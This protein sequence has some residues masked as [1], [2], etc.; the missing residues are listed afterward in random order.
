M[1]QHQEWLKY[2][3]MDT[4]EA[5]QLYMEKVKELAEIYQAKEKTDA[6]QEEGA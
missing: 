3:G 5:M 1:R 4:F 2:K 6:K